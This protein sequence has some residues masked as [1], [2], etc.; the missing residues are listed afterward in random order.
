MLSAVAGLV[1]GVGKSVSSTHGARYL[2]A[3]EASGL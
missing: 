3:A 2:N 1:G